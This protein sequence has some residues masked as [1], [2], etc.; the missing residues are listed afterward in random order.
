MQHSSRIIV[1]KRTVSFTSPPNSA[2]LKHD[3]MTEENAVL[4]NILESSRLGGRAGGML[5]Q[6]PNSDIDGGFPVR[7][8]VIEV[9]SADNQ[10]CDPGVPQHEFDRFLWCQM[11]G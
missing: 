2:D 3:A 10:T 7:P 9:D 11:S 5:G 4:A 6:L 1:C 8:H